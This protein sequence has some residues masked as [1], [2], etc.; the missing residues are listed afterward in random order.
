MNIP[1]PSELFKMFGK[2]YAGNPPLDRDAIKAI[3]RSIWFFSSRFIKDE[4][5]IGAVTEALAEIKAER[6]A[7]ETGV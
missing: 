6:N 7:P 1:T 3:T 2:A 5:I 4:D